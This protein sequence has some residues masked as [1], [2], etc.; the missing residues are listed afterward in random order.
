M[1]RTILA[2]AVLAALAAGAYAADKDQ[3][4]QGA[5]QQQSAG[6]GASGSKQAQRGAQTPP[7]APAIVLV[8]LVVAQTP[9]FGDGCWVRLYDGEN[10]GGNQLTLIGPQDMPNMRTAFGTDWS[11][12]FDSAQTGPKATV[13]VYDNENYTQKVATFQPGQRIADLDERRGLF[14]DIRSLKIACSGP[15]ATGG[16]QQQEQQKNRQ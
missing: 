10:Y 2:G 1:T 15:A 4:A 3:Q 14:E 11:G 16:T 8:P 6:A 9:N 12:S 7:G 13:Q 5:Q